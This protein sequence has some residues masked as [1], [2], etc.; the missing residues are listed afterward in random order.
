METSK[1][2]V[3]RLRSRW[4]LYS[5][6]VPQRAAR[7]VSPAGLTSLMTVSVSPMLRGGVDLGDQGLDAVGGEQEAAVLLAAMG[8]S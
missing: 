6:A 2:Y 8:A 3:G 1:V 4:L 5:A 7:G